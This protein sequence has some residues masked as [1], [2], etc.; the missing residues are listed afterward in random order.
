MHREDGFYGQSFKRK[1]KKVL[2][3]YPELFRLFAP[4]PKLKA[5]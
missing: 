5:S 1:D 2:N 3:R 4:I